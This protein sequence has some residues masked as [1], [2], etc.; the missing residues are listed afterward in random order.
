MVVVHKICFVNKIIDLV[1]VF[2]TFKKC[3][4]NHGSDFDICRY[5]GWYMTAFD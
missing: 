5:M 1:V 2:I 3:H 4:Y